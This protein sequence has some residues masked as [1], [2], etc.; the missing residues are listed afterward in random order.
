MSNAILENNTSVFY[1]D[2]E[3]FHAVQVRKST[4][5][6]N[7]VELK[8]EHV[9]LIEKY[10]SDKEKMT[11]PFGHTF[12]IE[13]I[14][15]GNID[16]DIATYGYIKEFKAILLA[17]CKPDAITLFEMAYVLHGLV[18]QLTEADVQTVW[19]GG[20]FNHQDA[21]NSLSL[22]DDEIVAAVIPLG[23]ESSKKRLMFDYIAP[24]ILGAKNRKDDVC[25]SENFDT[26]LYGITTKYS[27]ALDIAR[28]APS[29][30]NK[31]PWRVV[32]DEKNNMIHMYAK[33]S[34]RDEV[35]TGRKQYSCPPEY[36]DLGTYYR[37][38]ELGLTHIGLKGSIV[39]A[40]PNIILPD[41]L[42]IEYIATWVEDN[43]NEETNNLP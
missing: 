14:N 36:L 43:K 1:N 33:F 32:I 2:E 7:G 26:P 3:L 11:G 38:L 24:V 13:F 40:N 28:R 23:Y 39:I 31:Q 12:R 35:G 29:A 9:E 22:K 20:A 25:F 17:I 15:D 27:E 42:D 41:N 16:K 34:L 37:S 19:I 5:T 10:L 30:K 21:A 4:R 8:S 18:L 6:Y